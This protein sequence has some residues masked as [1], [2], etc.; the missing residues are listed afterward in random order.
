MRR[1]GVWVEDVPTNATGVKVVG[2]GDDDST[3]VVNTLSNA[4]KHL[5]Y[6]DSLKVNSALFIVASTENRSI[7]YQYE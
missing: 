3:V 2:T 1:F 6:H 5:L 4:T 7:T